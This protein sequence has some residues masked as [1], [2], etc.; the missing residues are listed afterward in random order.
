MCRDAGQQHQRVLHDDPEQ[1]VEEVGRCRS[2]DY[3][4]V[5]ANP[6]D[7]HS[8]LPRPSGPATSA[9]RPGSSWELKCPLLRPCSPLGVVVNFPPTPRGKHRGTVSNYQSREALRREPAARP[10]CDARGG[11][12]GEPEEAEA[13]V[14]EAGSGSGPG[15]SGRCGF[16]A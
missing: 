2:A 4:S 12:G 16:G 9:R 1:G 14:E 15:R 10:G 6:R 5:G 3:E 8:G 13:E 11:R 7:A